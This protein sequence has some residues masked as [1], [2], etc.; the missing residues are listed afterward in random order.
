MKT[1]KR[2]ALPFC[3]MMLA[4]LMTGCGGNDGEIGKQLTAM[5]ATVLNQ[6]GNDIPATVMLS[7]LKGQDV[8]LDQA[9]P[10]VAQLSQ[11][12]SVVLSS[13]NVTDDQLA[14]LGKYVVAG[15]LC[16]YRIRGLRM[17]ESSTFAVCRSYSR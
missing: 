13:T 3:L 6:S 11:V 7:N 8:D 5:G 15:R 17:P 4:L 14:T 2:F 9:L 12:K 10:L 1:Q 16:S